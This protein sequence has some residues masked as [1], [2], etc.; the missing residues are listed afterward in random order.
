MT[1]ASCGAGLRPDAT[2]CGQ[3]FAAVGGAAPPPVVPG[4]P[5]P[6]R[7]ELQLTQVYSRWQGGPTSFGPVGRVVLTLLVLLVGL[8]LL[9]TNP[10]G[11]VVYALLAAPLVLREVWKRSAVQRRV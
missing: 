6:A 2:W 1:C 3:C 4:R 8:W 9:E 11:G 7:E 5:V 10:I